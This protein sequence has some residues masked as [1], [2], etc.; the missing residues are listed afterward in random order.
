M[1]SIAQAPQLCLHS[2][3]T[4][5]ISHG[6]HRM[7]R[8]GMLHCLLHMLWL[9]PM[10]NTS[11][12]SYPGPHETLQLSSML[13]PPP[14]PLCCAPAPVLWPPTPAP[15]LPSLL[16]LSSRL[17]AGTIGFILFILTSCCSCPYSLPPHPLLRPPRC[18]PPPTPSPWPNNPAF[19]WCLVTCRKNDELEQLKQSHGLLQSMLDSTRESTS[20]DIAHL[21]AITKVSLLSQGVGG[22]NKQGR[23]GPCLVAKH[24]GQHE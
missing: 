21:T 11:S 2:A 24:A 7:T 9:A 16:S 12:L 3:A 20:S 13:C 10:I 23:E 5:C 19:H 18:P 8:H 6:K 22:G 1:Q 17:A 15:S 14:L 4:S